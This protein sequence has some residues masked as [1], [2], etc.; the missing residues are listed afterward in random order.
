M[1]RMMR[2]RGSPVGIRGMKFLFSVDAIIR[3]T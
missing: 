2:G 3:V 1:A